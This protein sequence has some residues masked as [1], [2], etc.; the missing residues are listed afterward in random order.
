MKYKDQCIHNY[1]FVLGELKTLVDLPVP[2]EIGKT[3][4]NNS[5]FKK[6][7]QNAWDNIVQG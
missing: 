4:F 7:Q 2:N 6:K 1:I 3:S 5:Q